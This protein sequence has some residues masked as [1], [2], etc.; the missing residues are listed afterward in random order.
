[1]GWTLVTYYYYR[2]V[3]K[4]RLWVSERSR[5]LSG[6]LTILL[7][8]S[9]RRLWHI[10]KQLRSV[11]CSRCFLSQLFNTSSSGSHPWKSR[12]QCHR[13]N[14]VYNLSSVRILSSPSW[15]DWDRYI[16]Y[17][18][19]L[20]TLEPVWVCSVI[21]VSVIEEPRHHSPPIGWWDW[22]HD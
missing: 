3:V 10:I 18:W 22:A 17:Y 5:E 8:L 2:V 15:P 1:M 14:L 13:W 20:P 19:I 9:W 4:V 12:N 6:S 16:R 21:L 7:G 11:W